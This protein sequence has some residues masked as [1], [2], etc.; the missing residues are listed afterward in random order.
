MTGKVVDE[1]NEPLTGVSIQVTGT[2]TGTVTDFDGNFTLQV[3]TGST[4]DFSYIGFVTQRLQAQANMVVVLEEDRVAL[5]EVVIVGVGYGTMRKSDLTGSIASV[6]QDDLKQGVITSAEQLLQGKVSGLSVVQS[7]GDPAAGATLRLRGGTSLSAGNSPLIVVD[8]IPGV[9]MNTVQPSEIVSID[10]LKDASA[11]AIY[12]SRGA[13]G[14]IIVTTNRAAGG[15][16]KRSI[17]Y[18]GYMAVGRASKNMDLLSTNQWREYVRDNNVANAID[19]GGNTDWQKEIQRTAITH[20]HNIFFSNVNENSGFSTSVTY[21]NS[22]GIIRNSDMERLSGSIAAHQ[23]GLDKRLKLEAGITGSFDSWNPI[24]TCIFERT[25]NL[26]PTVP[27]YDR[28]GE[29]TSIGGTNTENPVELNNNRTSDD[30]RHHFLGYGKVEVEII[31]GLKATSNMSYEY[32][33]RQTRFY[34][35]TYAAME[36]Q[37][38]RGRGSRSLADYKTLQ[39]EAYLNYS[40]EFNELHRLNV[41]GGYSYL[42]NVYEG[43]GATHRGFDSDEFLYNN[44]GA[45]SDYRVGDVYSYKGQSQLASFFGRVNYSYDGKYMATATLRNDGSSRFGENHKWGLFPSASVA[46]SIIREDFMAS[47]ESW[48]DNLKFRFG[49]GITGNQDGI[50]KYKSLSLLAADGA[51]YYDPET[52]TWKKS[53]TPVQNYN[54]DLKWESTIQLN[55]GID[56]AFLRRF[57]GSIELYHKK[58]KD[59]LWTY[60][61]PQPPYLVGTMLANVGDLT[62]KGIELAL[63][64]DILNKGDFQWSADLTVAYNH[65]EI[66][67]LSNEVFQDSGL[68]SGSLHGLRGLSGVYAQIIKEGY[69]VGAFWGPKCY[70]IDEDGQ[71]IINRDED[72]EPINEY[73]G[74]A[75]PKINLGF[76]MNFRWREFDLNVSTYGMFG[77]K[78][79]NATYMSMYDPTRLPAQNVPDNFLKSG[80][81]SDPVFSDYWVENGSFLRLQS[82]TL[83]YTVKA[84][85]KWGLSKLRV[86][87]TGENLFTITGYSGIDPEVSTELINSEGE[88]GLP[89]I[90]IY[91]TYPRP[92]TVSFGLNLSF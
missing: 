37:T 80:I 77:Q 60:P 52:G 29:Y 44:L 57:T 58:T 74:S 86:Y 82:L 39:L 71:Y 79:L 90:D 25:A 81:Q 1:R 13:N 73:L 27:V 46:W 85:Q 62:N 40:K 88:I 66:N 20:S 48:L 12:G 59:L 83:G 61:V 87:I 75:Q 9:D 67:K 42:K 64:A 30:S 2:M 38:E 56:F 63:S 24:D 4:L 3:A 16:E 7:S 51:S 14:V 5:G 78:V 68:K 91:S 89:G 19:Y 54:P 28:N 35:P 65:Q 8:G 69:P 26:N 32:N 11:S 36:G 34:L 18:N 23:Y 55:F 92:R 47:T 45:G 53:Y 22:Q 33:S 17:E 21:L 76:A 50:G 84:A 6:S 15:R 43:F 31:D 72:G 10:V 41:L 70:G 49:Y